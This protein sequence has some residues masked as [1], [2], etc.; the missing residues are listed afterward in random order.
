M[1]M[2]NFGTAV[3]EDDK[4]M[5]RQRAK[6]KGLTTYASSEPCKNGHAGLRYV[7]S[8]ECRAC[9]IIR[10]N[11]KHG[12]IADAETVEKRRAIEDHQNRKRDE[13]DF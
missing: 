7:K 8:N 3:D 6:D 1:Q 12:F 2:N 13:Y 4:G 11:K 9:A 5:T 10:D